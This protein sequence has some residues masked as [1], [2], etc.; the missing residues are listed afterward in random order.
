LKMFSNPISHEY[1]MNIYHCIGIGTESNNMAI[2]MAYLANRKA[3]KSCHIVTSNVEHP[4]VTNYLDRLKEHGQIK[5]TLVPVQPNGR[6]LVDEVKKAIRPSTVLVTLMLA[7]NES[8]AI[9]PVREIAHH[10]RK[11]NILFHTD[12]AQAAGKI[13]LQ[14]ADVGHPDMMTIVGHKMGAAKGVACLYVRP[15]CLQEHGRVMHNHGIFFEGG[16]QEMGRRSGTE[17]VPYCVGLGKAALLA[18]EQLEVNHKH[19]ELMRARL[20]ERLTSQLGADT[21][22]VNGPKDAAHRLPN[23]LSISFRGVDS[24]LLLKDMGDSVAASAGASCHSSES[25]SSVLVAMKVPAEFIRGTLRL[26]CGPYTSPEEIDKA[27]DIIATSVEKYQ[28]SQR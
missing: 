25:I 28:N 18:A 15:G 7:N 4:A 13:S 8:G 12:A 20:L 27:A 26:T 23:T 22:C 1:L 2:Y 14:L 17:N 16:G 5:V 6:V 19:M 9:M 21:I 24:S 3:K 11:L 10:C